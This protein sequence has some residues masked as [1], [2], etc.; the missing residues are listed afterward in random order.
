ERL[1]SVVGANVAADLYHQRVTQQRKRRQE[2]RREP[3]DR[4]GEELCGGERGRAVVGDGH[5]N[6]VG[7]VFLGD[8]RTPI[9]QAAGGIDRG[10]VRRA[11]QGKR[12][13]VRRE[14]GVI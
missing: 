2:H 6:E 12:Q 7:R 5:A 10:P 9:E 1:H 4:N 8:R 3:I 14:V 13:C 11:Q